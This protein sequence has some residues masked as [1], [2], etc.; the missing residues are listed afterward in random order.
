MSLEDKLLLSSAIDSFPGYLT[1]I[2]LDETWKDIELTSDCILAAAFLDHTVCENISERAVRK[3]VERFQCDFLSE[4][5]IHAL[6]NSQDE[7]SGAFL[8]KTFYQAMESASLPY[9]VKGSALVHS[10]RQKNIRMHALCGGQGPNS[11][12]CLSELRRL[13]LIYGSLV[14]EVIEVATSTLNQL[15]SLPQTSTYYELEGIDI[16]GWLERPFLK[17]DATYVASAPVSFPIIGLV[18][19]CHYCITCK[20]LGLSP[21]ELR[22]LLSSV[23]GHSQGIIIAA[24]ISRSRSWEEFYSSA[25]YAM[26]VLFWIGFESYHE[27]LGGLLSNADIRDSVDSAEGRPSPM[28]GIRGLDERAVS[29]LLLKLNRDLPVEEQASVALINS[30]DNIVVAGPPKSLRGV[31]LHLRKLKASEGTDQSR[32]VFTKRKPIIGHEF[33]PI[34]APFH[35]PHLENATARILAALSARKLPARDL[36]VPIY[37]T[38]T[39]H[40]ISRMDSSDVT[41][42]LVR[43]VT[44]EAVDWPRA[45]SHMERSYVL[46]FGPGSIGTLVHKIREGTGTRV[47]MASTLSSSS[48]KVGAKLELFASTMPPVAPCWEERYRPR[49]VRDS[50]GRKTLIT[51]MTALIG[52]RPIMV[53]GLTPTTVPWDF[54]AAIMKAGYHAELA[55]GGYHNAKTMEI[56]IRRI[57]ENVSPGRG[58][59][60][61][62]IYVNPRAIAWQ[63]PLI[64]RLVQEGVP[65][66]GMTIGAGIPSAETVKDY[67]ETIGLK[68]ISFKPGSKEAILEVLSI[69]NTYPH[70]TFGLQW[71]GGRGGGHH[72]F[73]DFHDPIIKTYAAIRD[74]P[75][76]VLI[77]GSGFGDSEGI[78][79]YLT[80]KWS[81]ALGYPSMPFDGV[82]LGSR[83]MVAKEAHTSVEAKRLIVEAEGVSD[84]QWHNSYD[85]STGGV[86]TVQSEMG[87][88]IHKLATRGALFWHELDKNIFSIRDASKRLVEIRKNRQYI[89][90]RL[91]RDF[92]KPWFGVKVDG[93]CVDI[94]DMTY[95]EVV[96]RLTSL[97]YV[98]FQRR[99]IDPSYERLVLDFVIRACERLPTISPLKVKLGCSPDDLLVAFARSYPSAKIELLHPDDVSFFL[100]LCRRR[101]QKPVNFIPAL[102]ENFELWF[103]KD[104]LWQSEDVDAVTGR[105][106]QRVCIIQGPVAVRHS[107]NVDEPCQKI[108]DG[109]LFPLIDLFCSEKDAEELAVSESSH[110]VNCLHD[111]ASLRTLSL[112][113]VVIEQSEGRT[114]LKFP[115]SGPLPGTQIFLAYLQ[116]ITRD[117]A[118]ACLTEPVIIQGSKRRP[119]PVHAAISPQYGHT[120]TIFYNNRRD[121]T[122]FALVR[123]SGKTSQPRTLMHVSSSDG[124]SISVILYEHSPRAGGEVSI[125]FL[126]QFLPS[127]Y[128]CQLIDDLSL[129]NERIKSFYAELWL[130]NRLGTLVNAEVHSEFSSTKT[131]I[132]G[133]A[134]RQFMAVVATSNPDQLFRGFQYDVVPMDY[135]IV[136]A[137]DALVKPL[138]ISATDGNLMRLLH[139]SNQFAYCSGAEPLRFGDV[140]DTVARINS[141]T[142]QPTGKLIEVLAEIRRQDIPVVRLT[143]AFFIQGSFD[144]HDKTFRSIEAPEMKIVIESERTAALVLSRHWLELDIPATKLI[145]TTLTFRL[146]S[147]STYDKFGLFSSL[148]VTGQVYATTDAEPTI[149]IGRVFFEAGSCRGN[150]VV[151]FLQRHGSPLWGPIPLQNPG[152]KHES[153]IRIRMPKDTKAYAR[154]S[155]DC[156]PIHLSP[157]FARFAGLSRTVTHGMFTSAAVRT[158][159]E[160]VVADSD[161][162]R[163]RR[164]SALFESTVHPGDELRLEIIHVAMSEGRMVINVKA[165]NDR[166]GTKVLEAEAEVDQPPTVYLFTGQGSQEKAM[167]MPLYESSPAARKIWDRG[168]NH[169]MSLYGKSDFW[170]L[171]LD[172]DVSYRVFN[173]RNCT[174]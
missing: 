88:P 132:E 52:V 146:N 137:W 68:H 58:I 111:I 5:D 163:F 98:M 119:N 109:I 51:R 104:S 38:R 82:L 86:L 31:N 112:G 18:S 143:S 159:V 21:G 148:Q 79:P 22:E 102:D 160:K 99:W 116:E 161:S 162:N 169:L 23:T 174:Q 138:L 30:K 133:T 10:A 134:V 152:W 71:T 62:L 43:M 69:A 123:S 164:W 44:V 129:R 17:V 73:E 141:V 92:Q 114:S 7:A 72:S 101:H 154:V 117:W 136:L 81:T 121:I 57:S 158:M 3:V 105:D 108:L 26:E 60:C 113:G 156:N 77:A 16:K 47:I 131:R 67:V 54:V 172:A 49:L 13:H 1:K 150:P 120:V 50:D 87:Q 40:D 46:D 125:E 48:K 127:G 32:I 27:E 140:V 64:R 75:N 12:T 33:L 89:I 168:D 76:V 24:V 55:G 142:N 130:G 4:E 20:I 74:C 149:R 6:A 37:H 65:I 151:D 94:E 66:D 122:S 25:Q 85:R 107:S 80:G 147:R 139:R 9:P 165:Y 170:A 166:T 59:T 157:S 8:L 83:M 171:S 167:G 39:G 135:C 78:F 128:A 19:L 41:E 2:K 106:A 126:Y 173:N 61:N 103:K 155:M 115:S 35:S 145:D 45:T 29:N 70:F 110:H 95:L 28:L 63:I 144:D 97:M 93:D 15:A 124:Q 34:S 56:A 96:S 53:A 91:N 42:S 118:R 100:G 14:R 153:D 84:S 11:L 36:G 90:E